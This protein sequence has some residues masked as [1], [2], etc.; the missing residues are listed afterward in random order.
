MEFLLFPR[1]DRR[2]VN[3]RDLGE[4]VNRFLEVAMAWGC[5]K[6]ITLPGK[7]GS[8]IILMTYADIM[9][10]FSWYRQWLLVFEHE[11]KKML[12]KIL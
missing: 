3:I 12:V 2:D 5:G 9:D 11:R 10:R 7:H 4:F 8:I 6:D 1:E